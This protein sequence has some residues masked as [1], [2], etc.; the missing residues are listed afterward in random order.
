MSEIR[1][2]PKPESISWDVISDVLHQ[3]HRANAEKG[4]VQNTA[5]ISG[6]EIK[7]KV[8]NGLCV[9]AIDGNKIVGTLSAT[10]KLKNAWFFHGNALYY[11]LLAILPEYQ[12]KGIYKRLISVREEYTKKLG[13]NLTYMYTAEKNIKMQQLAEKEGFIPV[14][15]SVSSQTD[16]YSVILAK[17]SDSCPYSNF[18]CKF[19][20]LLSKYYI[21]LR[22]KQGAV[23][24][25]GI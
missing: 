21:K 18:Y 10:P 11:M 14:G 17:W 23:K 16:Y 24:R 4:F 2:I 7:G 9:V 19:R 25:F 22:Y 13:V 5:F 8:G 20:F 3:A 1:I 15:Y 6:N 12:G